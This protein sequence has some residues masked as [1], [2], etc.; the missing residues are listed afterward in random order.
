VLA[1]SLS[2][3]VSD[4]DALSTYH[5]QLLDLRDEIAEAEEFHDF[6]RHE[7]L[8]AKRDRL[9]QEV[10]RARGLGGRRRQHGPRERARKAVTNAIREAYKLIGKVHPPLAAHLKAFLH[11]GWTTCYQ[12]DTPLR[13]LT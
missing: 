2:D 7:Q 1:A 11:P 10:S 6:A 12:P 13:W 4:R 9:L 5:Q 3:E 8:C